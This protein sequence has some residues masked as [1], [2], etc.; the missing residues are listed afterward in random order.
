MDSTCTIVNPSS[1]THSTS[2][3]SLSFGTLNLDTTSLDFSNQ[4]ISSQSLFSQSG[5]SLAL[6]GMFIE[7]VSRSNGDGSV[8][9][10]VLSSGSLSIH[11]CSFSSC[12]CSEGHGGAIFLDITELKSSATLSFQPLTFGTQADNT[13]CSAKKMGQNVFLLLPPN[14]NEATLTSLEPLVPTQPLDGIA[15]NQT[16]REFVEFGEKTDSSINPIGSLLYL[17]YPPSNSLHVRDVKG[18]D[19]ELC[20]SELLPCL[21]VE[22]GYSLLGSGNAFDTLTLDSDLR[23]AQQ[24]ELTDKD[25]VIQAN[26]TEK[27]IIEVDGC[28]VIPIGKLTFRN[29]EL[30]LPSTISTSPFQMTGGELCLTASAILSH[31]GSVTTSTKLSSPVFTVSKGSLTIEGSSATPRIFSFFSNAEG[32][33]GCVMRVGGDLS[34]QATIQVS[35]CH[36]TSCSNTQGAI[37]SFTG[38]VPGLVSMDACF[39]TN[40]DGFN[41]NDVSATECWRPVLTKETIKNSFS[42]SNLH[43]LTIASSAADDLL[44][45][46]ILGVDH[47][48]NDDENCGLPDISCSSVS[49]AL[50]HCT[51]EKDNVFA[52]RTIRMENNI[53]ESSTLVVGSRQIALTAVS[54]TTKLEWASAASMITLTNGSV[55]LESFTLVDLDPAS[56]APLMLLSSTGTLSLSS[57]TFSGGSVPFSHSLIQSAAGHVILSFCVFSDI[58]LDSHALFETVSTVEMN[59][60]Q[61]SSIT[62]QTKGPTILS[63]ALSADHP[64]SALGTTFAACTSDGVDSWIWFTGQNAKTFDSSNWLGTFDLSSPRT[65]VVVDNETKVGDATLNPYSIVYEMYPASAQK[66]FVTSS[67][68]NLDHPLCGHSVL[69]CLTI[70]RSHDLTKVDTIEV[71]GTGNVEGVLLVGNATVALSGHNGH[72]TLAMI[73]VGQVVSDDVDD[74]GR[75]IVSSLIVDVS[76]S[77][78]SG[79]NV[80]DI[81]TGSIEISSSSLVSSKSIGLCLVS[82]TGTKLTVS[83]TSISLNTTES[84][85]LLAASH[86]IVH[87]DTV[88]ISSSSFAS[89]PIVLS[90]VSSVTVTSLDMADCSVS[91]LISVTNAQSLTLSQ[92]DFVGSTSTVQPTSNSD[93][94]SWSTGLI[95]LANCSSVSVVSTRFSSLRQGALLLSNSSVTVASSSFSMNGPASLSSPS[96]HWNIRC[97]G[98]S[99]LEIESLS[100]GDGIQT[101]S[102]WIST[103]EDCIV[104]KEQVNLEPSFFNPVFSKTESKSVF[105]KKTKTYSVSL[106]GQNL[107][108]CG[109]FLELFE[110]TPNSDGKTHPIELIEGRAS[111]MNETNI[112]LVFEQTEPGLNA[113]F[114][115]RGQLVY[116][117]TSKSDSF[118]IKQSS[119]DERKALT[120]ETMI[121]LGPLFGG[122]LLLFF[123]LIVIIVVIRRRRKQKEKANSKMTDQ[124]ELDLTDNVMKDD[125]VYPDDALMHQSTF[126]LE[127]SNANIPVSTITDNTTIAKHLTEPAPTSKVP[128][129]EVDV[130]AFEDCQTPAKRRR[131]E[132]LYARLHGENNMEFNRKKARM[133]LARGICRLTQTEAHAARL[134]TLSPHTILLDTSGNMFFEMTT[135][136]DHGAFFGSNPASRTEQPKAGFADQRWQA[137][138]AQQTNQNTNREK[139]AVFSLGLM[140]WEIETGEVPLK[141]LDA[142][143]AQRVLGQGVQ[144]AME[145]VKQTQLADMIIKCILQNPNDRPTPFEVVKVLEEADN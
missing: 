35:N 99:K 64:V 141:E 49:K 18:L 102:H 13:A 122:L 93:L 3:F 29:I 51:Q 79:K 62:R 59:T 82:F 67:S 101:T 116:G 40:N 113:T 66:I 30:S 20:G 137:P 131:H 86:G 118:L 133:T 109:L 10:S 126:S 105:N 5:G 143:N 114:E 60:C 14:V 23:L 47:F 129:E 130:I 112:N 36:F 85:V 6:S 33:D 81:L 44:P 75:L 87:I 8:I 140:L 144:L 46:S 43:H 73:G 123:V 22:G 88:N 61:F 91:E 24:F 110:K 37:I 58:D 127:G 38:S 15:F 55:S 77:T 12:V 136:N 106:V 63:A 139:A 39:F 26:S 34:T 103:D 104:T 107:I 28:F 52:L 31:P 120:I 4:F 100:G 84:G 76:L 119:A 7:N 41:S 90:D 48:V 92:S 45:F 2:L 89:T 96:I 70:D 71:V 50:I 117:R 57:I 17:V 98:S 94:C 83:H 16:E 11:D 125:L 42:E 111:A 78:L 19:H 32:M 124:Q 69:R 134:T 138:E 74:P 95:S 54:E 56:T 132:S 128:D 68:G 145:N 9:S 97:E 135:Q 27:M 121:W 80:L 72:G 1:A 65:G 21:T 53:R 115:W 142:A 108:P 25:A